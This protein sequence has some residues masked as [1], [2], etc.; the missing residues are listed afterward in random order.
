MGR[1]L[2]YFTLLSRE[3]I[4]G[5]EEEVVADPASRKAQQALATDV[6]TRVH[7]ADAAR[8][9]EDVSRLIFGK[10]DPVSL[11]P[12]ALAALSREMPFVEMQTAPTAVDALIA[13]NLATS[14]SAARRLIE[15]G[16]VSV[17]ARRVASA[18]DA[19]SDPLLGEYYLIKKGA[20]DF[21]LLRIRVTA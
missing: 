1:Y 8:V 17:N 19:L 11:S 16:G 20:R 12:P 3:E 6:T 15:Q 21:G 2:R 5:L 10:G 18:T 13:L 7:G 9:A 14:K 4:A